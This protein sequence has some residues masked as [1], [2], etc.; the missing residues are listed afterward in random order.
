MS[1][2]EQM[3]VRIL[4]LVARIFADDDAVEKEIRNLAAHISVHA[5]KAKET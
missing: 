3:V 4:L 2:R 5:P 1:F